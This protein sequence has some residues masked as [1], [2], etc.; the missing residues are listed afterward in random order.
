VL[1]SRPLQGRRVLITGAAKGI[2]AQMVESFAAAGANV[3]AC[4]RSPSNA[5][6]ERCES[7]ALQYD[8]EVRP[9]CFD[10]SD[11]Q[12]IKKAMQRLFSEKV[13]IDIL[14]NN[15]GVATGGFLNMTTMDSIKT[16]F[17][18]N[19]FAPF[20]MTQYVAKW[21]TRQ[22][23]GVIINLGSIAGLDNY[24]GYT[25]YGSSKAA[26]MQFTKIIAN[27]LAP[28]G[29]RVNAIAPALVDTAMAQKM[30]SK[31]G[32][33]MI[34]RSSMKRLGRPTEI[35]DLAVYLAS[36]HASFI[37]GQVIRADGGM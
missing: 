15:A 8:V 34:E 35:A 7:L 28:Y 12:A 31:A 11:E 17:Q 36:D 18:V 16:S 4:V 6:Q 9:L 20:Q 27:E 21:M 10:L 29:V 26:L 37:N 14:V 13:Y 2:G 1:S 24:A 22:R 3:L 19:F 23:S 32:D 25:A 33:A 5:V 30:E